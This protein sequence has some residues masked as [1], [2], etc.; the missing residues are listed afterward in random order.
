A[1]KGTAGELHRSHG[2]AEACVFC[3]RV[4]KVRERQ[5][6][7]SAQSL[8]DRM[9]QNLLLCWVK[10]NQPVQ[11]P[12]SAGGHIRTIVLAVKLA[13]PTSRPEDFKTAVKLRR[14]VSKARSSGSYGS[15]TQSVGARG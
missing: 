11:I 10:F 13:T 4:H 14:I 7:N 1:A 2:V 6:P 15:R 3:A 8:E 5:L 12:Q 9:F